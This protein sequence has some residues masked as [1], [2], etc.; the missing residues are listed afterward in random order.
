[1]AEDNEKA[2]PQSIFSM[3]LIFIAAFAGLL[4]GAGMVYLMERPSGNAITTLE[5]IPQST[6]AAAVNTEADKKCTLTDAELALMGQAA[7]GLVAGMQ[8]ADNPLMLADMQFNAPD[9]AK[10]SI[11]DLRGKTLLVNLWASWC[12]PCRE[13]MPALDNLQSSKGSDDF[14][15]VAINL[16]TGDDTKPKKFL[17]DIKVDTLGFYRDATMEVF[18]D[19]K[20]KGLAIGLPLTL[21]IDQ[22]GCLIAAMN[23]PADW[24]SEDAFSLIEAARSLKR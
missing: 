11:A 17:A 15:V 8:P 19:L 4:A 16:D 12:A 22:Q 3:K 10:M 7:T 2:K 5:R 6:S 1:M 23:G 13:E 20:R 24:A 14:E 9:G 18:N 21:L